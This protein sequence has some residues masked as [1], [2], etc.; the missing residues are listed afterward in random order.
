MQ[1]AVFVIKFVGGEVSEKNVIRVR[2]FKYEKD[3]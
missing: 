3:I 1:V 2:N